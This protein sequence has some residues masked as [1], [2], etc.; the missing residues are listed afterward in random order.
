MLMVN[1]SWRTREDSLDAEPASVIQTAPT[2]LADLV[3]PED[4]RSVQR[5]Q[6]SLHLT[7][8]VQV[9]PC[10]GS[11]D[12]NP[13][14]FNRSFRFAPLGIRLAELLVGSDLVVGVISD[15]RHQSLTAFGDV[16]ILKHCI[17]RP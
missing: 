14:S 4:K 10:A 13:E 12:S 1:A 7:R 6:Q 9:A 17:A 5:G 11:P 3:G 16:A 8:G 15:Q 2:E